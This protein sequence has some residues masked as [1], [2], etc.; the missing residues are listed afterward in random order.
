MF[1]LMPMFLLM[2]DGLRMDRAAPCCS[3]SLPHFGAY[4][5]RCCV[6]ARQSILA[7]SAARRHDGWSLAMLPFVTMLARKI[8]ALP[9][10]LDVTGLAPC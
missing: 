1:L 3:A 2:H 5:C 8:S 6:L 9:Q 4:P 10:R 7:R